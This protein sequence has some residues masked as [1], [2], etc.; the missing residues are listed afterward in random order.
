MV[1][2]ATHRPTD[3]THTPLHFPPTV[4]TLGGRVIHSTRQ[5]IH[6]K[7]IDNVPDEPPIQELVCCAA[8]IWIVFKVFFYIISP[9]RRQLQS[10]HALHQLNFIKATVFA[11]IKLRKGALQ[12][13]LGILPTQ[14]GW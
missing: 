7:A 14:K 10:L 12:G 4:W 6:P 8:A 1:T 13:Q 3:V 5:A 9:H 11:L 2:I